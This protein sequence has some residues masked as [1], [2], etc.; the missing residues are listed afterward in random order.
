MRKSEKVNVVTRL[1][2]GRQRFD[3]WRAG[4][5]GGGPRRIP[6]Q[7][8]RLAERLAAEYGV[9][10]TRRVLRLDYKGL[11]RRMEEAGSLKAVKPTF[12]EL[13]GSL[14]PSSGSTVEIESD[15]GTKL[16]VQLSGG[17]ALDVAELARGFWDAARR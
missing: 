15:V 1:E 7:L 12:M 6:E 3:A 4:R 17:Q 9:D 13:S 16:R 11:K 14:L 10:R 8:W 2:K 5:V